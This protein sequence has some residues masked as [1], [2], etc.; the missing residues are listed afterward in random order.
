LHRR[1]TIAVEVC[2]HA[3]LPTLWGEKSDSWGLSII[4]DLH[5]LVVVCVWVWVWVCV[6]DCH[7]VG[8]MG[9]L[10]HSGH[11]SPV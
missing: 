6:L 11:V 8:W 2:S 3:R 5:I 10:S 9:V 4:I 1:H 7:C